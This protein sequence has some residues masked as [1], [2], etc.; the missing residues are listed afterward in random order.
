MSAI[1]G[2]KSNAIKQPTSPGLVDYLIIGGGLA[3]ARCAATLR[4]EGAEG[5][6]LIVSAEEYPPYHRPP[7]SKGLLLGTQSRDK[8]FILSDEYY[9]DKG[10][11]LKL[12]AEVNRLDAS[13]KAAF[14][15]GNEYRYGQVLI[16][17]GAIARRLDIEGG[18]LDNIFYL[19]TL[20][21]SDRIREAMRAAERAAIIG[22]GFIGMELASAFAQNGIETTMII[23]EDRLWDKLG[24]VEISA[25]FRRLYEDN[26][27]RLVF[28]DQAAKVE[29]EGGAVKRLVTAKGKVI[30]C[31][32]L[33]IGIGV[34]PATGFLDGAQVRIENGVV[35]D[36]HLK[37]EAPGLFAAGDVANFYDPVLET[38]WRIEHW[39]NA[40]KQGELVAKNMLGH[41][42]AYDTVSYFFSEVFKTYYEFL[43]DNRQADEIVLRGS[44]KSGSVA[45][46]YLKGGR[47]R[48]AFLLGHHRSERPSIE[49][50][51]RSKM[52]LGPFRAKLSD[53]SFNLSELLG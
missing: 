28:E 41:D 45:V 47:L 13:S 50:L 29:G 18:D 40:V 24:S 20:S 6:I 44:F 48:A 35:V 33:C 32:I 37:A 17:T 34:F 2:R 23:R 38:R 46:L 51:V 42:I 53:E 10:I 30:P 7:L 5:R 1:P 8:V 27:V 22:G 49:A 31:D 3:G 25:F 52:D 21:D 16:C 12:K 43:G 19:R 39:D 14:V 4:N 36:E 11:E 9:R 26:G 15:G